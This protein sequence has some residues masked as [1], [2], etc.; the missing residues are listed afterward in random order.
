MSS[1]RMSVGRWL[2]RLG[3]V[4]VVAMLSLALGLPSALGGAGMGTSRAQ[5]APA[6]QESDTP[7]TLCGY[8]VVPLESVLDSTKP[9]QLQRAGPPTSRELPSPSVSLDAV[10]TINH[11]TGVR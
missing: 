11:A 10:V 3:L 8:P 2:R 6:V 9:G 5:A 7:E 4:A 1:R